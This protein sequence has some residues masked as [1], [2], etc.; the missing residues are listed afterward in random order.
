MS[1][2]APT[3]A[4]REPTPQDERGTPPLRRTPTI[5]TIARAGKKPS[6]EDV[7]ALLHGARLLGPWSTPWQDEEPSDRATR[8]ALPLRRFALVVVA[9][10]LL[11]LGI[12]LVRAGRQRQEEREQATLTSELREFLL[13]GE[14]AL[15]ERRVASLCSTP[16][17]C[18]QLPPETRA[19]VAR[20]QATLYRWHDADPARLAAI[21]AMAAPAE[22]VDLAVK[23]ALLESAE[24]WSADING[25]EALARNDIAGCDALY[26][27]ALARARA[28]NLPAAVAAFRAANERGPA[29]LPYLA[30][31]VQALDDSG[32]PVS[33]LR[34]ARRM[35]SISDKS[36]WT[37]WA[38]SLA[39]A[40][41]P[42]NPPGTPDP[43]PAAEPPVLRMLKALHRGIPPE[44]LAPGPEILRDS[45][46]R[47]I[48]RGEFPGARRLLGDPRA[49][50]GP[51][52]L[53]RLAWSEGRLDEAASLVPSSNE[54]D[55]LARLLVV[56]RLR[57]QNDL[58][59]ARSILDAL[60]RDWGGAW[61]IASERM[62]LWL[63]DDRERP[64][65]RS[66]KALEAL[67]PAEP[68][69]PV[70]VQRWLL[71]ARL[72]MRMGTPASARRLAQRAFEADSENVEARTLLKRLEHSSERASR[73]GKPG[74][75]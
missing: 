42:S 3:T 48:V 21:E 36:P 35:A 49:H 38:L 53:A 27:V 13:H 34:V 54:A 47:L 29:H 43:S 44:G 25:L 52:L 9:G 20:A 56:K 58:D 65:L 73:F 55:P 16:P 40:D 51:A 2:S 59:G 66:R 7:L 63:S 4:R 37:K 68:R 23:N 61:P 67:I 32:L 57:S 24:R 31:Q 6:V 71:L 39:G 60:E 75:R 17:R 45:V 26:L 64:S 8:K 1:P 28:G 50:A 12:L 19:L 72:E 11:G 14:L 41:S 30:L 5:S 22:S 15:A 33:A 69:S 70:A 62:A 46:N 18:A 10:A 74:R